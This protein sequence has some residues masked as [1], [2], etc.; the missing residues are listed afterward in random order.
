MVD[1]ALL[2]ELAQPLELEERRV[3]LVHV[4][5]RRRQA[6][7][8]QDAHA[9]DAEHEL[10]AQPVPAVAAVE[11]VR[12]VAGPVGVALDLRVEEVERDAPDLR[13]PDADPDGHEPA[14][15]VGELDH[16]RHRHEGERQP[17]RVVARIALDLPVVL[18]EPLAE[19]PAA[20]EEA[21]ADEGDAELGSRLQVVAGEDAETAG[22]D[23][24]AL[25]EPELGREV[26][27]E[28]VVRQ[29]ALLPPRP[30]PAHERES[31]LHSADRTRVLRRQG[32][33]EVV[34]GQLGQ[35]RGR[36]VSER[37]EALGREL[38]EERAGARNPAERE[39]ARDV[40][41]RRPQ[42]RPVVNL[43]HKPRP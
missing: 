36:V 10:L 34:V 12:D 40:G 39:V 16:R 29:P 11:R 42:R 9:A 25:V 14:V 37:G 2:G 5:D 1:A 20:V 3:A 33:A 26:R 32:A 23:R 38:G 18:V 30:A 21:D 17:V 4:E 13:V 24:Q 6:E 41:E 27:D 35:E 8:A 28:E 19:V 43:C 31:L 22:V 15:V 7:A